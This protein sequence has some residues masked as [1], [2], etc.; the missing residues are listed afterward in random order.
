MTDAEWAEENPAPSKKLVPT[1]LWFCGGGCL[2][3]VVVAVLLFMW[4][5]GKA[6]ELI[7]ADVQYPELEKVIEMDER[8]EEWEF[9][10]A[11][12]IP[13]TMKMYTFSDDRGF[14]V[15]IMDIAENQ[16]EEVKDQV[17]NTDFD[18]SF[19]GMGGRKDME[20]STID[21][22]GR[23]IEMMTYYQEGGG[24][25]SGESGHAATIDITPENDGGMVLMMLIRAGSGEKITAD[26]VNEVLKPLH[27]GPNR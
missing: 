27:I 9:I 14:A 7:D 10:V 25:Q 8:P 2:L 16:V 20:L 17:F 4:G 24:S 18:G 26:E 21:V 15:I 5:V 6:Q 23:S 3:A 22:Q 19:A 11:M 13:G 1:W 12:P